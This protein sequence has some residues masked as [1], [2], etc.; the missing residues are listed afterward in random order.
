MG[1]ADGVNNKINRGEPAVAKKLRQAATAA[2]CGDQPQ[3]LSVH[4]HNS[5]LIELL[6]HK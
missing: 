3:C 5:R 1:L 4:H 2:R 6:V